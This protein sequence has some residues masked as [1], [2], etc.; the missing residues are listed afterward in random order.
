ML[1]SLCALFCAVFCA[2]ADIAVDFDEEGLLQSL[3]DADEVLAKTWKVPASV[4]NRQCSVNIQSDI[5][6]H[7]SDVVKGAHC[8]T[9][10]E[11]CNNCMKKSACV[12]WVFSPS[13]IL[14]GKPN[15]WLKRKGAIAKRK[16]DRISNTVK[17]IA[18]SAPS[19][20]MPWVL[21]ST[22]GKGHVPVHKLPPLE[23]CHNHPIH[24]R[25]ACPPD[26]HGEL[27][28][29]A[30]V[31][32]RAPLFATP[33]VVIAAALFAAAGIYM[34]AVEAQLMVLQSARGFGGV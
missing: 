24:G 8:T 27:P 1:G 2:A 9:L 13:R 23:N 22:A 20:S 15:C 29:T 30:P 32:R 33:G 16:A 18:A 21:V 6:Y 17:S 14:S 10:A 34:L 4:N 25:A 19:G 12:A 31:Q 11:C 26:A 28:P 7:G 3:A 5:D